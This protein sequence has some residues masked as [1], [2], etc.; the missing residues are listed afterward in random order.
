MHMH[1]HT[2]NGLEAQ[3]N[4]ERLQNGESLVFVLFNQKNNAV[5][6]KKCFKRSARRNDHDFIMCRNRCRNHLSLLKVWTFNSFNRSYFL[7]GNY[8]FNR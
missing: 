6:Y 4:P 2:K 7:L 5:N 3:E 1:V 8:N